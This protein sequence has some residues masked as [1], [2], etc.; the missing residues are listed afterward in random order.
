MAWEAYKKEARVGLLRLM[1]TPASRV[2]RRRPPNRR[3]ER[4]KNQSII[5][6]AKPR[7]APDFYC[8]DKINAFGRPVRAS[9]V[10][11]YAQREMD[12]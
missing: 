2:L 10:G 4:D 11:E 7:P 5:G 1:T 12:V 3:T 9:R 6:A 8:V